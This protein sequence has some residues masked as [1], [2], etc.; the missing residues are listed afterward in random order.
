MLNEVT[1]GNSVTRWDGVAF[2][3]APGAL[4]CRS[5]A[6]KRADP[7]LGCLGCL[8]DDALVSCARGGKP[9][10]F[11]ELFERHRPHIQRCLSGWLKEKATWY[12]DDLEQQ[13]FFKAWSRLGQYAGRSSFR[14]WL[15]TIALNEVRME[16]RRQKVAPVFLPMSRQP[17]SD[18]DSQATEIEPGAREDL[19]LQIIAQDL[20][21]LLAAAVH[22]LSE[23]HREA[24]KLWLE[25]MNI[26]EIARRLKTTDSAAKT[27]LHRAKQ[28]LRK[29][30][31]QRLRTRRGETTG[32]LV[33]LIGRYP[34]RDVE[35]GW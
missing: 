4:A 17:A 1:S 2:N 15:T 34:R 14:T 31:R 26:H 28:L 13:T 32:S 19:E 27:R 18:N 29:R 8:P 25:G 3:P 7:D 9:D 5:V 10:C 33:H 16:L 22:E 20:R 6:V 12:A 23:G 24:L 30:I 21:D 35:N 11:E